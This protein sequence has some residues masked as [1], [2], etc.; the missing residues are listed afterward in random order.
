MTDVNGHTASPARGRGRGRGRG[1]GRGAISKATVRKPTGNGRRGRQKLYG[2]VLAQASAERQK[3]V[4]ANYT[5]LMTACISAAEDLAQRNIDHLK[6]D[7][8]AHEEAGAEYRQTLAFLD[9]RLGATVQEYDW[10]QTFAVDDLT[11]S[12]QLNEIIAKGSFQVACLPSSK[13]LID[14][15]SDVDIGPIR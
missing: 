12:R 15:G 2:S 6:N 8:H 4:K 9:S 11:K 1:T 3:E 14:I 13:T 7:P 10:Q 5:A